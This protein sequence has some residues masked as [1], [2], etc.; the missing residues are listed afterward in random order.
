MRRA[1]EPGSHTEQEQRSPWAVS[2]GLPWVQQPRSQ[3]A[4]SPEPT[5]EEQS[6]RDQVAMGRG[7]RYRHLPQ[8][9]LGEQLIKH[10]RLTGEVGQ[11]QRMG[12]KCLEGH[13]VKV[14]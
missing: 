5:L 1:E 8:P 9:G 2:R 6:S 13:T 3:R 4:I 11:S 14:S 12:E 7:P 10:L